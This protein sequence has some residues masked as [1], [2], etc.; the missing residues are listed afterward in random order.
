MRKADN[1]VGRWEDEKRW[2]RRYQERN[3]K[4]FLKGGVAGYFITRIRFVLRKIS[5]QQRLCWLT[6]F[7]MAGL[8]YPAV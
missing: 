6:L 3:R 4:L 5:R 2:E 7:S 1:A 8:S